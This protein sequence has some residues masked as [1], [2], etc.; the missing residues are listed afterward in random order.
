MEFMR[1][2]IIMIFLMMM[3]CLQAAANS[4]TVAGVGEVDFGPNITATEN[5]DKNGNPVYSLQVKDGKVWRGAMLKAPKTIPNSDKV[6]KM[7]LVEFL[8]KTVDKKISSNKDFLD[9]DK[10]KMMGQGNNA[11]VV[12]Y[13]IAAPNGG[14]IMNMDMMLVSKADGV[15]IITFTCADSDAEYWRPI[16]QK[17]VLGIQ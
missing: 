7:G 2:V 14:I 12:S 9:A 10:A 3:C 15:E 5:Q 17:V 13:K 6:S 8:N 11:A 16:I 4:V 1:K